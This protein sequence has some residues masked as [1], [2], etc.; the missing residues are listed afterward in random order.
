MDTEKTQLMHAESD[1]SIRS[2]P[3]QTISM[4]SQ[5]NEEWMRESKSLEA[6]NEQFKLEFDNFKSKLVY[7]QPISSS[8]VS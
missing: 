3:T 7:S 4:S 5:T 8:R 1:K 6:Q 2:I